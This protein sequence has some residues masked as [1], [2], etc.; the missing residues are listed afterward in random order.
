MGKISYAD[1][2]TTLDQVLAGDLPETTREVL[3]SIKTDVIKAH[4]KGSKKVSEDGPNVPGTASEKPDNSL[5]NSAMGVYRGFLK[6]R[7]SHLDMRGAKA[8]FVS[9]AM[10][11]IIA[12]MQDFAKSN[13]RP[14]GD[15]DIL[16]GIQ[17]MFGHWDRLNPFHRNR[18]MLPDIYRNIEEIIPMIVNGADKK[19]TTNDELEQ[20]KRSITNQQ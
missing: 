17:F 10:R 14:T 18:I 9:T 16:K 13:D 6:S 3:R 2:I 12:Y 7:N 20:L 8:K 11:G 19:S 4:S 1:K 15:E 5:Y